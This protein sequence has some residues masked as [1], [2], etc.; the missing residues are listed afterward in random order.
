MWKAYFYQTC[1]FYYCKD[2]II[3][4]YSY[5]NVVYTNIDFML[6]QT[7]ENKHYLIW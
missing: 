1:Y 7:K 2:N 5:T 6:K 3:H 4:Y